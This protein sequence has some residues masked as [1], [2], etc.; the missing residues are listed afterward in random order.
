MEADDDL[1]YAKAF[2][3]SDIFKMKTATEIEDSIFVH[4]GIVE[5]QFDP[6]T[7]LVLYTSTVRAE[8]L[9]MAFP[10]WS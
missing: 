10:S 1:D 9:V 7:K 2:Y 3:S 6:K 8:V 4:F 5:T